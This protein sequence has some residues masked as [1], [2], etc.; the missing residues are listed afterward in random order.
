MNF[1]TKPLLL[2]FSGPNGLCDAFQGKNI[3]NEEFGHFCLKRP[4]NRFSEKTRFRSEFFYKTTLHLFSQPNKLCGAFQG[5]IVQDK[6]FAR[7]CLKHPRNSFSE[8]RVSGLNFFT[9]LPPHPFSGPNGLCGAFQG[10]IVPNK[11]FTG[12]LSHPKFNRV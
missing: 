11:N 2:L 1:F 10:K 7:F 12:F 4:R 3:T 6:N 5:K 9:K 8:K